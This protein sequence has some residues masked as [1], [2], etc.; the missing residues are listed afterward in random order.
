M[1]D[2]LPAASCVDRGLAEPPRSRTRPGHVSLSAPRADRGAARGRRLRRRPRRA[3]D[4]AFARRRFDDWWETQLRHLARAARALDGLSPAEH[5]RRRP[6]RRSRRGCAPVTAASDGSLR[7]ARRGRLVRRRAPGSAEALPRLPRP[8]TTTT[9][10]TSPSSTARPSPSS[11]SARRATPT[12]RT[13]RTPGVNVVVGLREDSA[14]VQQ[15]KDAGLEVLTVADA[16]SA[17][18]HRD[19][20]RPRRAAPRGLR[21]RRPRRHRRGQPAALRPRLLDPLRRGRA[22]RRRR[23]RRSSRPRARA[24]SSAASTSRA[25]ASPASS[26]STRTPRATPR[27]SRSP[28]PRASAAPAAASSRRRFKEE[29]ETDLFG[30]QAV[31]CGGASAL[32]QAGFD[33][34][35]EAGYDP[36][37]AYFECLHELKLIVDLMYEKGL[38]GMRYSISNTA[39]YGDYTRGPRVVNDETRAEMKQILGEIQSGD[40]RAR[41]DRREPRRPG[42]LQAHARRA[43]RH[44]VEP[45]GKELRA[46]DGLDRRPSSSRLRPGR[47]RLTRPVRGRRGELHRSSRRNWR[48]EVG[49]HRGAMVILRRTPGHSHTDPEEPHDDERDHAQIPEELKPADGRFGCGPSKVRTAAARPR[50]PPTAPRLM[51]TSH[52][53]KPVKDLVGRV[54][55][56][57]TRPLRACPTATRS[58]SATAARPPSGTPPPLGLIRERSLHLTLRRVLHK[59]ATRADER[60]VPAGPDRRRGRAG[61]RARAAS[62]TGV[63][64]VAWAHNETSTGV[65]VPVQRPAAATTR[66]SSID[67]TSGA[68][69][70]PRRRQPGRR[71]L[72]RAAEVLRRRRR[73]LAGVA[74]PGGARAHRRGRRAHRPLDPRVALADHRAG[75]L[76]QGPDLQ[77][78]RARDAV[79]ARRRRSSG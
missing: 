14:S 68:G 27:R 51:G 56:G 21:E 78:A 67:A 60:A 42:E 43:G 35:V 69:G 39:E 44:Q 34:L 5:A 63:D 47:G 65:M 76:G 20:A 7:A 4:F 32:V 24:T 16:A 9:T 8:C 33:T 2:D 38:A 70:L 72:L 55:A 19:A 48:L 10:Q 46:H 53:Q 71:L 74:Q 31:L 23:R 73:P 12:R 50:W 61:R 28:T 59:F 49:H 52:R 3:V 1:A 17:R 22:A 29:T 37:M 54:R 36:Q 64:V 66:W 25:P 40:V 6:R 62:R 41:V 77:H 26:R 75:Q 13:S 45:V 11:A 30:E 57:L 15:A 79:P 58:R 18:R